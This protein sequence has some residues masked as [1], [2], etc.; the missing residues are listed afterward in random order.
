MSAQKFLL[1]LWHHQSCWNPLSIH[2]PKLQSS[3][4]LLLYIN[5]PCGKQYVLF[6]SSG[7]FL[8]S[9]FPLTVA[10]IFQESVSL[11]KITNNKSKFS[12][13]LLLLIHWCFP[14]YPVYCILLI[15][16]FNLNKKKS[17]DFHLVF[18]SL[19]KLYNYQK[20]CVFSV[21]KLKKWWIYIW[22]YMCSSYDS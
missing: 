7:T 4:S 20:I 3:D 15:R 17:V 18:F 10:H 5:H 14:I 9:L 1:G 16:S 2:Y 8:P 22:F 11:H 19:V 21:N 6:F 12:F 13:T